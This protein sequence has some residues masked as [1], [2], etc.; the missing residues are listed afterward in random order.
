MT[1]LNSAV[2]GADKLNQNIKCML[3]YAGNCLT[4]QHGDINYAHDILADESK[5]EFI[6]VWETAMT[7][8]AKYADILLPTCSA[9]SRCRRSAPA[10]TTHT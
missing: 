2:M 1:A 5:C 8:S 10:A 9:S 7:D 6:V 4:N 3:N